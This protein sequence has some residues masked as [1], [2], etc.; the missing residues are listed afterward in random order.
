MKF[1]FILARAVAF[2]VALMCRLLGVS[3]SGFYAWRDRPESGRS[4]DDARLAVDIAATHKRS[5]GRYGSPRVH[6]ELRAQGVRVGRKRVERLMREQGLCARPRRR[7][8][9]TTDSL[10]GDP[11]APN[12]LKRDFE[13]SA[14]NQVWVTDVTYVPT[15]EGW[16]YLAVI[17]DLYARRAVGWATS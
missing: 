6:A 17:L 14:P 16:L 13:A 5:R 9:K 8:C 2:P 12:L 4:R 7:F 1:A 3:T 10:H 11:I 15:H